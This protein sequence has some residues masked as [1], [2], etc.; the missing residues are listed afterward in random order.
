MNDRAFDPWIGRRYEAE[1]LHGA[2]LPVL[3]E[4][5]FDTDLRAPLSGSRARNESSTHRIVQD[6]GIDRREGLGK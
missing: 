1:G 3:G 2:S 4:S 6:W 5:Q